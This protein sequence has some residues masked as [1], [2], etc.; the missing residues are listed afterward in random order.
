MSTSREIFEQAVKAYIQSLPKGTTPQVFQLYEIA[1]QVGLN[2]WDSMP[3]APSMAM[4]RL[5]IKVGEENQMW[6]VMYNGDVF[7]EGKPPQDFRARRM[8]D[9]C[10]SEMTAQ[11]EAREKSRLERGFV[12]AEQES[13]AWG[14]ACAEMLM[15][16]ITASVTKGDDA[17][18]EVLKQYQ[19][20]E[21]DGSDKGRLN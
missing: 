5:I 6:L 13:Q 21:V 3:G 7:V 18:Q 9:H 16:V 10:M 4:S 12:S 15:G 17:V 1:R 8:Y 14:K 2:G 19:P 11:N 20:E